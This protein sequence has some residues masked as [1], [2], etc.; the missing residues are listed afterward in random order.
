MFTTALCSVGLLLGAGPALAADPGPYVSLGDSYTAAP[1]VL[2][3]GGTPLGCLRSD[4]NYPSLVTRALAIASLRDVSCSAAK[5]RH[6]TEPQG[7]GIGTNPPQFDGLRPDTRLVTVGIGGN[8][9]GLVGV[10]EK[11]ATLG[12]TAPT[13]SACRSFYASPSGDRTVAN[14]T[15][16]APKIAAM[17]QGIH[18]RSPLAR[19]AV[20]GYPDVLPRTGSGCYPLVPLSPDDIRYIDGL[21]VQTN[22]MLAEQATANG[23]EFVDTY[24][25]SVGHDVCTLPGTKWYE[26]LVP[27]ALAYPLHP[28]ALGMQST[29]RSVL[30]VLAQPQPAPVL[31]ALTRARRAVAVGRVLRVSYRLD[32]AATLT[33]V[34]QRAING[35]LKGGACRLPSR[36]NR[37]APACRRYVTAKRATANAGAG[38]GTFSISPADYRRR[39]GLYRVTVTPTDGE[40]DGA[41]QTVRFRVKR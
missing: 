21:I 41:A 17:V 36:A 3:Q 5:T 37:S 22:A 25:D 20:V 31:S 15:D 12:L 6:M 13:G 14:I 4:H 7:V 28:N 32:R 38:D 18:E 1:L 35:R 40:R 23:A 33:R 30:R 10:A 9:V 29:A 8:D 16:T 19:V 2:N 26:G 24:A 27:T 39:A 11:C 34:L